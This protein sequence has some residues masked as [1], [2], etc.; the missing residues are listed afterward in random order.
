M[1]TDPFQL[2]RHWCI[3][4]ICCHIE[5]STFTA[6]FFRI[7]NSSTGIPSPPLALFIVLLSNV[8][9]TS[10]SRMSGFRWM[11]TP[12]WLSEWMKSLSRVRLFANSW[13]PSSSVHG[14]LQARILEWVAISFYRGSSQPRNWTCISCTGRRILYHLATWEASISP[15]SFTSIIRQI[16]NS[17]STSL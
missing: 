16:L 2:C 17:L 6:S 11:I 14:I 3:F 5:C 13:P 9:L 1:K 12:S 15:I 7:W 10:H 4:Q 8:H